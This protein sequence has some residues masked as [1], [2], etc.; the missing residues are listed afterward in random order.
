MLVNKKLPCRADPSTIP[1]QFSSW[2][3]WGILSPLLGSRTNFSAV[4]N[5]LYTATFFADCLVTKFFRNIIVAASKNPN[6]WSTPVC[7]I[8]YNAACY[9]LRQGFSWDVTSTCVGFQR[10]FN[11]RFSLYR[12]L[13]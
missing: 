11:S 9:V 8:V 6:I 4:N 3:L 5:V 13:S 2:Q 7:T 12:P 1:F 10:L